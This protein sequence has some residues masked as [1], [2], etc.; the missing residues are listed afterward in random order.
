MLPFSITV[1]GVTVVITGG[2]L[3][4]TSLDVLLLP[5]ASVAVAVIGLVV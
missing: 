4:I 1:V 3:E 2:S 5:A